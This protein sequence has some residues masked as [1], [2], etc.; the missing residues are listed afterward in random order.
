MDELHRGALAHELANLMQALSGNLELIAARTT[1][2][3]ALRYIAN[4]RAAARQLEDL[5]RKL[6]E[7]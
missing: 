2:E 3:Q 6:R 1:D 4:A 5:T 7:D